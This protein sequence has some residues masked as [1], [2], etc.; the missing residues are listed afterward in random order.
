[1]GD[2]RRE[3]DFVI[4]GSGAGGGPLAGNLAKAGY[5]VCLLEAGGNAEPYDYVPDAAAETHSVYAKHE[6]ILCGGAFNSPEL[7]MLSGIGPKSELEQHGIP[8]RLD[9][10]GFGQNLQDRYEV[11]V[12]SERDEGRF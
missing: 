7:L 2:E 4:V 12:V 11:G 1:M 9:R 3:Y 6:V 5:R 8:V 10:P